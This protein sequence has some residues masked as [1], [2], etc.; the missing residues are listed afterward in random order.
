LNG[1]AL[2][3]SGIY[4]LLQGDEIV[5]IGQ[6]KCLLNRLAS[7]LRN[8]PHEFDGF[9]VIE[10][11]V[12]ELDSTER[13]LIRKHQPKLNKVHGRDTSPPTRI[14]KGPGIPFHVA[15]NWAGSQKKLADRL[16]ISQA[17]VSQWR[18]AGEVPPNRTYQLHILSKGA[19][20]LPDAARALVERARA[21]REAA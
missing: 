17:A 20:P 1:K 2:L 5:Y 19:I 6:S 12:E 7:H 18:E 16:S 13:A 14:D 3:G 11:A 4:L 9:H 8:R 10:C 15:V 21:G